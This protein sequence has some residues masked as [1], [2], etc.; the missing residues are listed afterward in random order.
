MTVSP[1]QLAEKIAA[2]GRGDGFE[3]AVHGYSDRADPRGY[4]A[5]GATWWLEDLHDMRASF[6]DLLARVAAGPPG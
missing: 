6:D 4:A 1:D 3:V 5:A 2:I